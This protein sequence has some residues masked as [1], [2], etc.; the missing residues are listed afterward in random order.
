V[1]FHVADELISPAGKIDQERLD[2][3]GRMGGASYTRTTDRFEL[4]RKN[5]GS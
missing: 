3:I 1:Q 4:T 2:A 5:S